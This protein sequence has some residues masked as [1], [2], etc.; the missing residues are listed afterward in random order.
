MEQFVFFPTTIFKRL[1]LATIKELVN[2][3]ELQ[4]EVAFH[5]NVI[6]FYGIT[7]PDEE[8]NVKEYLLLT[9]RSKYKLAYQ[10][11]CAVSCLHDEGIV[12]RDLHSGNVLIHQDNIKLADFGLS[13]R[14]NMLSKKQSEL[15]GVAPYID[16]KKFDASYGHREKTIPDT[17]TEYADLYTE[18]WDGEPDNRPSM[19]EVIW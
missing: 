5:S 1:A 18:C 12:H 16:P 14:I 2:E 4:H 10:L 19:A 3:L 13:R 17:P 8:G 7:A 9:W 6:N 15:F 11:A